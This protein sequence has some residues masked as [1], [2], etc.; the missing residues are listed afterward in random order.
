MSRSTAVVTGLVLLCL[1]SLAKVYAIS[2]DK[3]GFYKLKLDTN[4]H[5]GKRLVNHGIL[6]V[7]VA[8]PVVC[9]N[10]CTENCLCESFNVCGKRCELS[11]STKE[12]AAND[13][14]SESECTYYDLARVSRSE[15]SPTT[16]YLSNVCAR[17]R[18]WSQSYVC[19]SALAVRK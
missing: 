4:V 18:L 8:H 17:A 14:K 13:Q 7:T 9:F 6:N 19:S 11:S 3:C 12:K 1:S 16:Q 2:E 5:S 10:K 15:V